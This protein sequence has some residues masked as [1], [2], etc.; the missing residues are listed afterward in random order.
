MAITFKLKSEAAKA[1][2][3]RAMQAK[4]DNPSQVEGTRHAEMLAVIFQ[5][6]GDRV[7][8][9][10][11]FS[12]MRENYPHK[13]EVDIRN[14][15]KG[16]HARDPQPTR[17][18]G[19][20]VTL[21]ARIVAEKVEHRRLV[22]KPEAFEDAP[23]PIKSGVEASIAFLESVFR[24]EEIVCA[25]NASKIDERDGKLKPCET[26]TFKSLEWWVDKI[27]SGYA[28]SGAAGMWI[29]INPFKIGN[30]TGADTGVADYRHCLVEFDK[31]DSR[32][33][34]SAVKQ[35]GLPVAAVLTSGGKSIH[36]WVKVEAKTLEEFRKRQ[37]VVYTYLE[38]CT[39]DPANKNPSRL[40]R[41]PGVMRGDKEQQLIALNIGAATWADWESEIQ[42]HEL[43]DEISVKSLD[44]FDRTND[45]NNLI[46][47]R[48]L[49]KGGS[50][51]VQGQS[52]IGKSSFLMQAAI[53][54]AL[55]RDLFGI[56]PVMPLRSLVLQAE[57]DLGDMA[58]MY[59]D[60]RKGMDLGNAARK[61]VADNL[62]FY[63]EQS[64]TGIEFI[65]IADRLIRKT[66]AH[67]IFADPLLAFVGDDISKQEVASRFLRN[68]LNPVLSDTGVLWVWLHHVGKPRIA[69]GAHSTSIK[70]IS[71]AGF[72][73][74]ELVNWARE[75]A[76][77]TRDD[78]AEEVYSLSLSKRSERSGMV[79]AQD[80]PSTTIR[81][82]HAKG[83]ILWERMRIPFTPQSK[84]AKE[85]T[86]ES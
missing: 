14:A 80:K 5:L 71:Y 40:S 37:E 77:L 20:N 24:P 29:R 63:R 1:T 4:L 15:I 54:W 73:S 81:L 6:V 55:G 48:W 10:D 35:S 33:Q 45:P 25:T 41:L 3:S 38:A 7:P 8:D 12:K 46:G 21:G 78:G 72:G 67:V 17:G 69:Q 58:E 52:G 13:S 30:D 47:K 66:K 86:N 76:T 68:W 19:G 43:P 28:F 83:K 34:W 70:E 85:A 11:I 59:Q 56:K 57:N 23:A 49:C 74:S 44:E 31:G 27:R 50:L 26:G 62:R 39:P 53:T 51:I 79:D 2:L 36:A 16:A 75:I 22:A 9:G 61:Q 65:R 64:R 84:R 82:Q 18:L 32:E 42:D 60:V